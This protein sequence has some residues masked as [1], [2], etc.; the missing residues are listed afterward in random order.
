MKKVIAILLS[1]LMVVSLAACGG[2]SETF[3]KIEESST[4]NE[5][6]ETTTPETE[7]T[8][9]RTELVETEA[10]TE[11]EETTPA[12]DTSWASND[13]EKLI[14]QPPFEGWTGNTVSDS[15]YEMETSKANADEATNADGGWLY[16]DI[17][18]EYIQTLIDCGFVM[19]G[20][21]YNASGTNDNGILV[22]LMCGDGHA[23]ITITKP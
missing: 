11:P 23:W 18:A 1:I 16:Y 20:D 17:W 14:P 4:T 13:F 21:T 19:E 9:E 15:V 3:G 10:P 12:F 8:A 22:E 2:Q 6:V 7:E 5:Q